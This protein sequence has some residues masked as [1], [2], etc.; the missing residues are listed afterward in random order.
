MTDPRDHLL[1]PNSTALEI[2]VARAAGPSVAAES[3][4]ATL[5][6]PAA[7]PAALLPHMA[8]GE[9]V[10]LWP[11]AESERRAI[12]AASPR[13]HA[14]IGTP[15]GLREMARLSG[16]RIQRLEMPPAKTF[17]GFWDAKSRADWLAAHPEMRIY[18]Q[19]ERAPAEGWMAGSAHVGEFAPR[20]SAMARSAVRVE[21]HHPGGAVTPLVTHGW[22][23]VATDG[24]AVI[25]VA[26]RST[27][28]GLFA[29]C[30]LPG[31]LVQS[32][33]AARYWR[34]KSVNY[35]ARGNTLLIKQMAPSLKPMTPDAEP[36]AE[37]AIR[38]HVLC[39]G[40][41][42]AGFAVRSDSARRIYARVRL[43]D[44]SVA[45]APKYGPSYLGFTR[46]SSPPFIALAH[47]RM[48]PRRLPFAMASSAMGACL[49]VGD[50][51]DRMAPVLDAMDWARAAHDKVLIRT[52]LHGR[53]RA[54]RIYKAG[55]MLAGHTVN[56]S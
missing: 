3:A 16:A 47:V 24:S 32:D 53:A 12:V 14:L 36:V 13:L 45:A 29:G 9:D 26:R 27:G 46:L 15:K 51:A 54:S 37:R 48:P 4:I 5:L 11:A 25:G 34:V 23:D 1:P 43:H 6:N 40:M 52:R 7:I 33:A 49:A 30:A 56:R 20:T 41:P 50:A 31:A 55:A 17:L 38:P 10:P 39:A 44:Q 35:R 8:A 22:S 19:R 28:R 42:L 18:A 21:I 2:A